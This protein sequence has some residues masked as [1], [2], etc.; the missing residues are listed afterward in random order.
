MQ[1]MFGDPHWGGNR[2]NIGWKLMGFPGISLD[3][4]AADQRT[5]TTTYV[6]QYKGSAYDWDEFKRTGKAMS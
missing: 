1:G 4:K 3:I 6:S 2:N 5:N